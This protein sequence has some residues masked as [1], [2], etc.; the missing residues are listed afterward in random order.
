VSTASIVVLS[1][2]ITVLVSVVIGVGRHLR[3]PT[4]PGFFFANHSLGT[5]ATTNLLLSSPFSVNGILYQAFLGY[6][7]GWA[8]V[9]TQVA[10]S[11]SYLWLSKYRNKIREEASSRTLHGAI[12]SI[13]GSDAER[14]A[15][16]ATIIGF[17]LQF[18]WEIIVGVSLFGAGFRS[19]GLLFWC[20]AIGLAIVAAAYTMLGGLRGNARANILQ[21]WIAAAALIVFAIFLGF[22]SNAHPGA[23][24]PWDSGSMG[25]LVTVLGVGGLLT[26]MAFS[27]LWQFVDMS[28]WQSIA[29]TRSRDDAPRSALAWSAFLIFLFPGVFGTLLGMFVRSIPNLNP[30][31]ILPSMVDLLGAHP[32]LALLVL[33]GMACAMLSTIDGLMLSVGQA[34]IFDLTDRE[35]VEKIMSWYKAQEHFDSSDELNE[36]PSNFE[37]SPPLEINRLEQGIFAKSRYS[38]LLAALGGSAATVITTQYFHVNIFDLVYIVTV[39]QMVLFPVVW[40]SLHG[41]KNRLGGRLSIYAGL[42]TGIVLVLSGVILKKT[43][44]LQ[45]VP[46]LSLGASAGVLWI[47]GRKDSNV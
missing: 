20:M 34:V 37:V 31:N 44:I 17:T 12:G 24:G 11:A 46:L 14:A 3:R 15:A 28:T 26:N 23:Q 10:W 25:R 22:W 41:A 8:A 21:N 33:S 27:L 36:E 16:V 47:V 38:M 35:G 40:A 9:L 5:N 30:D 4:L 43:P 7:I 2:S 19:S 1:L 13:F 6:A 42:W 39:A 18:G 45:W 32:L 29:S